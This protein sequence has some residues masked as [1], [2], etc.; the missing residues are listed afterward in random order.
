[1]IAKKNHSMRVVTNNVLKDKISQSNSKPD[2]LISVSG[3]DDLP[4]DDTSEIKEGSNSDALNQVM[5]K[6][7]MTFGSSAPV[8]GEE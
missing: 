1:M 3:K 7:N 8:E 4:A 6:I 2:E 5:K